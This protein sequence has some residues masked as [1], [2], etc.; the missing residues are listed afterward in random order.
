MNYQNARQFI[1]KKLEDEL[2]DYL[3]Y[4]SI[5]HVL[6]V[7]SAAENL[8]GLEGIE[9]ESLTLLKTAVL[10]HDCG[11]IKQSNDHEM[12]GCQIVREY[13]PAFNYS[14]EQIKII[15]DMI[16]AT[17]IPQSPK[18]LLEQI[19]CDADLDYLGRDDF[20]TIGS[21][22]F[23]ELEIYGILNDERDWNKLQLKF[24]EGHQ[25][26]TQ[27]AIKL[28]KIKKDSHLEKIRNIVSGYNE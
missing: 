26:F 6:D 20:W 14:E 18:N 17:K 3:Y 25:Y 12:I 28:R 10:Y 13:L 4:H 24:L 11:F 15:C 22:L 23:K 27:S 5:N 21:N 9:G 16:M 7:L 19:I 8:A 2:P 1:L